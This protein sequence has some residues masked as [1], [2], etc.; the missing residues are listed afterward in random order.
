MP[1]TVGHL[2]QTLG[3]GKAV[4]LE[5]TLA[6]IGGTAG[7]KGAIYGLIIILMVVY[8]PYAL[9]F[10]SRMGFT[11]VGSKSGC[12]S[13]CFHSIAR[14][15]SGGRRRTSNRIVTDELA[16]PRRNL[17][18][19]GG[20]TAVDAVSFAVEPGEIFSMIGPN[21]AGKTSIFNM[22]SRFYQ[23]STGRIFF[24]DIEITHEP[25]HEIAQLGIARTFQ[26]IE[27]FD[28]STV[29]A[30]LLVD[31]IA[32]AQPMSKTSCSCRRCANP[33]TP[34]VIASRKSSTSSIC[35]NIATS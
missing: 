8:E 1:R 12:I 10:T 23:P 34:T 13:N 29:L 17:V 14:R 20:L 30:N 22:I 18:G 3:Y 9:S 28:N 11:G 31:G 24:E 33:N 7:L 16:A 21:G 2:A 27:L 19:Y 5:N 4:A 6:A 35:S 26:N 25:A 32:I 15:R